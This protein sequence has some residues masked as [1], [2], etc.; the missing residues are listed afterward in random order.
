MES[1]ADADAAWRSSL[2][3]KADSMK[4]GGLSDI[5]AGAP[6]EPVLNEYTA[7]GV[8]VTRRPDD[9][10]G[11]ARVSIGGGVPGKGEYDYCVFRGTPDTCVALLENAILAIRAGS[12]ST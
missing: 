2:E 11:I 6:R 3:R 12:T 4:R 9:E 1:H 5:T 8:T 7:H 10:H